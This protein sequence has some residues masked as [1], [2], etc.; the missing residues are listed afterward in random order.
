MNATM[1]SGYPG[2][3]AWGQMSFGANHNSHGTLG[4]TTRRNPLQ[5]RNPRA[6]LPPVSYIPFLEFKRAC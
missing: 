3:D 1:G 2:Y 6:G 5:N 4:A